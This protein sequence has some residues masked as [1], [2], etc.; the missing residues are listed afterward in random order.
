M[1]LVEIVPLQLTFEERTELEQCERTIAQG[2]QT[3]VDVGTALLTIRDK[4]LYREQY[5]TFEDYC[6]KQWRLAR[7]RAYQLMD[8]AQ[9]VQNVKNFS[10]LPERESHAAPLA[11]LTSTPAK[12]TPARTTPTIPSRVCTFC[13]IRRGTWGA[14][15]PP[16]TM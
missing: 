1:T 3:F 14:G 9:V 11:T 12:T 7:R 4:R 15:T 8:A 13:V 2:L 6:Q 5:D 10:H 16:S